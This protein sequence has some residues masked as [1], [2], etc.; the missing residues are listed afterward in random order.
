MKK[1]M[2]Q[3]ELKDFERRAK[4]SRGNLS[5][6]FARENVDEELF[7]E[8][9]FGQEN[10]SF[11]QNSVY[12]QERTHKY[13]KLQMPLG[14][15]TRTRKIVYLDYSSANRCRV[16]G[17]TGSGKTLLIRSIYVDRFF[18][19][20]G[21][22]VVLSDFKPEFF[23]SKYPAQKKFWAQYLEDEKACGLQVVVYYPK[24]F[25][26]LI[27][28]YDTYLK[29]F[30]KYNIVPQPISISF[31]NLGMNEFMTLANREFSDTQRQFIDTL[32]LKKNNGEL[33]TLEEFLHAMR[34]N[35]KY[36]D[37]STIRSVESTFK[38]LTDLEVISDKHDF[39]LLTNL[40][41]KRF[42]I[43]TLAGWDD[44]KNIL[45]YPSSFVG[46][47]VRKIV[48]FKKRGFLQKT[49]INLIV[50]E[51]PHF[52]RKDSSLSSKIEIVDCIK[53]GRQLGIS[54]TFGS[55]DLIGLD[56]AVLDQSRYIIIA[57][58]VPIQTTKEIF[59][60]IGLFAVTSQYE[61]ETRV[62]RLMSRMRKYKDGGRDWLLVDKENKSYCIVKTLSPLSMHKE[63]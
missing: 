57:R 11:L 32:F 28:N 18:L 1:K 29:V 19:S 61:Y 48:E 26:K 50:D 10:R 9:E 33:K 53:V 13:K 59:K 30:N 62:R 36:F 49:K 23:V 45:Y 12:P 42:V 51:A 2:S 55:Q 63:E 37:N 20:Q 38:L 43:L 58:T 52:V 4:K 5:L 15:D 3:S 41:K 46:L 24:C 16:L 31:S 22:S 44:I 6:P 35:T 60:R 8:L 39:N 25:E 34:T 56:D 47:F 21:T 17:M 40:E 54:L 14:L 7:R 27:I